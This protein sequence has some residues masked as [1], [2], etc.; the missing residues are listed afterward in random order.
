MAS[1]ENSANVIKVL[2]SERES[3]WEKKKTFKG[4]GKIILEEQFS[5][6]TYL[7][8]EVQEE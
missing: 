5:E 4:K 7:A 8:G 2:S 1:S 3:S 6:I